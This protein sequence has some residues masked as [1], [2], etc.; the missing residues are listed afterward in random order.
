[1]TAQ[2]RFEGG[3]RISGDNYRSPGLRN[4]GSVENDGILAAYR[5]GEL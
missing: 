1:M 4:T 3:V 2:G 5:R